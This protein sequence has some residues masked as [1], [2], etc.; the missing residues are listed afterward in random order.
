MRRVW[1]L[2]IGGTAA[3]VLALVAGWQV[4]TPRG[5]DATE[6]TVY[7]TPTCGCCTKWAA[8][9]EHNG[10]D[11]DVEFREN[12]TPVKAE[13]GVGTLLQTC[14]TAVVDGYVVEGHVP[15]DVI[16]QLLTERPNVTGI[17][18]PGM[19]IGSPGME[20][21]A[22]RDRYNVVAFDRSGEMTVYA[23]R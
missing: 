16:R 14:H 20:Q 1:I 4:M 3:A 19:P 13:Y 8:Y 23:R 7:T 18:V 2:R 12:L 6:V 15:V 10:F 22:Q 17:A 21:G 5:A 11:V 9:L